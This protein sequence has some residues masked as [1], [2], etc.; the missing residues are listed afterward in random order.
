[1]SA[2]DVASKVQSYMT[3]NAASLAAT[4]WASLASAMASLKVTEELRWA[5]PLAIKQSLESAFT[6]AFGTKEE[7]NKVNAAAAKAS[8]GAGSSKTA[9][10]KA[11]VNNGKN[12]EGS[13]GTSSEIAASATKMF[14]EGFLAKLHPVGGNPQLHPHLREEHL[15]A[16]QGL[17]HTRFPPEPNG[18]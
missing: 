4:T 15:K 17:V 2:E 18:G 6:T 5:S 10:G 13:S 7:Y 9:N 8:K 12:A 11:S 3:E 1:M 16:T 14:Q